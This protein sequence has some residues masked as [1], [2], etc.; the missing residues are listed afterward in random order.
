[1]S[2]RALKAIETERRQ[3]PFESFEDFYL[4]TRVEYPVAENLIRLGVFDSLEPNRTELLWRLPLLHDRLEALAGGSGRRQGQ[5][6]AFLT[7]PQTTGL[8][9]NWTQGDKVRVELEL[10]GLT[11]TCHPLEL[12]EEELRRLG[13]QMS[14]EL[15][16]LGDEVRVTVAGVYERAQNPWM[17]SG[18]RT[19]FLTLEDVYGLFE[20]VVFES[21]LPRYAPVVARATYFLVKGRLQNNRKRGL[22][23]VAEEIHDLEDV[24]AR[25]E[26][27]PQSG[28]GSVDPR[29]RPQTET[30]GEPPKRPPGAGS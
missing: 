24:L 4:R 8:V 17:R 23:I 21:K 25:T 26:R 19:M 20:C 12:Y 15:P 16:D 11:V 10:L 18:R 27:Q 14:Y 29:S 2:E 5:L 9:R 28:A 13:V 7:P 1:M 3:A 22:A 30:G 6:K